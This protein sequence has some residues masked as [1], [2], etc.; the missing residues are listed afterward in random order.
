MLLPSSL[1]RTG[2][3]LFVIIELT[4]QDL[5]DVGFVM[6]ITVQSGNQ[7]WKYI[8]HIGKDLINLCHRV[9]KKWYTEWR[10]FVW[11]I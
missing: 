6:F 11:F 9:L 5:Q 3:R 10:V 8:I 7:Y 1:S 4:I 2:S